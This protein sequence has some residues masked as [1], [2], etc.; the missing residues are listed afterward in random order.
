MAK[1]GTLVLGNNNMHYLRQENKAN[2]KVYLDFDIF[3]YMQKLMHEANKKTI[4]KFV[5]G[6]SKLQTYCRLKIMP[7]MANQTIYSLDACNIIGR[8]LC[9][10]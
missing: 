9:S 2:K 6:M 5:S 3:R 8:I 1:E 7:T 4:K 10:S